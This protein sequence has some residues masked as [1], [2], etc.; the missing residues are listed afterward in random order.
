MS[1]VLRAA[2]A[3]TAS[4]AIAVSWAVPAQAATAET[5]SIE[6]KLNT[7]GILTVAVTINLSDSTGVSTLSQE[8]PTFMDRDGMR[9]SFAVSDITLTVDGDA[10]TP[11]Q[12]TKTG[13]IVVSYPTESASEFVLTY[14]VKGASTTLVDGR[15]DFTWLLLSGLNID[16]ERVTGTVA[17]PAGAVNYDCQAGTVGALTTCSTYSAG[18]HGNPAMTLTKNVL[19]AG[20]V[21]QAEVIFADG[22]VTVTEDAAV[23][24]T[25]GRALTP[26]LAQLG[27]MALVLIA[28]GLGLFGLWRRVRTAGYTGEPKP[29]ASFTK[30]AE[31]N[32]KFE[33]DANSRPGMVGTLVD[34][35]VDPVDILATILDLSV[36]GHLLITEL[37]TSRYEAPDWSFTRQQGPDDLKDYEKLL[38]DALTSSPVTVN[39]I[40]EAVAP[41]VTA[42]Q[43][44]LYQ[45]VLD[46]GWFSR[47]P[48]KRPPMVIWGFVAIALATI[49]TLGIMIVST[50]GLVGMAL[51]ALSIVFL[52]IAYH[53]PP[54]TPQ[55]AAIYAG[56]GQLEKDLDIHKGEEVAEEERIRTISQVL[57]YAIV[58]GGWDEW[59]DDMVLADPDDDPDP[60][61]LSWFHAPDDWHLKYLPSS[62][63]AFITVVTGRLFARD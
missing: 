9:Y 47:L 25:L 18:T 43:D 14:S 51:I 63:D 38:L 45:E 36:R 17:V 11:T 19:A 4:I 62:L 6:A 26:G 22:V 42:V 56:F 21:V 33:C 28:G 39:N 24:W 3:F 8:I 20:Q 30:D 23:I 55:G 48:F 49:A 32:L 44:A 5:A 52:Y 61:A 13:A 50:W 58:L 35:S 2:L 15:V 1:R 59:V 27:V 12:T 41:A 34:S 37:V 31:G 7:D 10:V 40:D 60:E 57:P 53:Q 16:V 54:V 29:V 46:S